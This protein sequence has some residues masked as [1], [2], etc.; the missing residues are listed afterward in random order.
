MLRMKFILQTRVAALAMALFL[1]CRPVLG[2]TVISVDA[3]ANVHPI[4]EL[5]YGVNFANS[6]QLADLNSPLNRSGGNAESRYNWNVNAHN[7]AADY[8]FESIAD[9]PATPGAE[10]DKH[11]ANSKAAGA[12]SMITIPTL[13]WVAKD[14]T[15]R[16]S[17]S[18][19]K[20]G[21][22]DSSDPFQSDAG[23]GTVNG[24]KITNNF[25]TDANVLL[26]STNQQNWVKH[27]TNQWGLAG[28][29]GV[30]YYLMDNEPSLWSSTHFDVHHAGTT[31]REI[32]DKF[33]EYGSKVKAVDAGAMVCAPE[34]WGWLG[35]FYSGADQEVV[36]SGPFNDRSTNGN[37]DYIPWFLDQARQFET[38]SGQRLLDVLTVHYYPQGD[39]FGTTQEF[40]TNTSSQAQLLRNRSTRSL[41]DTNYTDAS[42]IQDV[43]KLVPRFK[44]WIATYY[45][46][47]KFGLTE[48][49][50]GADDHIN[51]ATA[52]ADVLGILGREGVDLAT[53]WT[54]P[55]SN[56][57]VANA[58]K[59]YRN[60][61]GNKSKFGNLSVATSAPAPDNVAAFGAL[62]TSD[63][64]LTVMV[65]N[66]QLSTSATV[67]L[68]LTNFYHNGTAQ[69]WQLTS[70]NVVT[71][72]GAR[73][74]TAGSVT[75]TVPAQSV[76][77]FVVS[78]GAPPQ[79]SA[80]L[81][82]PTT[83][84]LTLTGYPNQRYVI[85]RSVDLTNWTGFVTNLLSTNTFTITD[86][87]TNAARFYRAYWTPK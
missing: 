87:L 63:G 19:A 51:G 76:T 6:N 86:G 61:D 21:Q 32:R 79:L 66:K 30:R 9:N 10:A 54:V 4:S 29:G 35:Y 27:L 31:L 65:I 1:T 78:A 15:Q 81:Q 45:P 18:I 36:P 83:L 75:A 37:M 74:V 71:A 8:F 67:Q 56:T 26:D 23:N 49:S 80:S 7:R 50:W 52:Q 13:G 77:L 20:Y 33:V 53:R 46:G 5:V 16:W 48:Y 12:D 62:R 60:Y 85:D 14:R 41:W 3:G 25:P 24:I 42:W 38:N 22:Q 58:F 2:Q 82:T 59:M 72:L 43:V 47:T 55:A 39:A 73:T 84:A 17:Y 69:L 64:A 57:P 28:G 34:E 68:A 70:T 40:S 11:V 44:S